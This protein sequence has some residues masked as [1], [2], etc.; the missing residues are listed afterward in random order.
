MQADIPK[1]LDC[2]MA[3]CSYNKSKQCHA[4]AITVG[5]TSCPLCDTYAQSAKKGGDMNLTGC[6]GACKTDSCKFNQSLECKATNGIRVKQHS[7]HP[8]CSTFSSR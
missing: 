8:D 7:D 2:D 3:D 6:V 4:I 5:D 1:I